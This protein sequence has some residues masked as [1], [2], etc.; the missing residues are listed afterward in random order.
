MAKLGKAFLGFLAQNAGALARVTHDTVGNQ[1]KNWTLKPLV[2]LV[3]PSG[4]SYDPNTGKML[5]KPR[6]SLAGL[7]WSKLGDAREIIGDYL[8]RAYNNADFFDRGAK[9][10]DAWGTSQFSN[11]RVGRILSGTAKGLAWGG[12]GTG[13]LDTGLEMTGNEDSAWHGIGKWNPY[14]WIQ[15]SEYSPTNLLFSYTTPIGLGL[16]AGVNGITGLTENVARAA[17][18]ATIDQTAKALAEM[19]TM[20]RLAYLFSPTAVSNRYRAQAMSTLD[21]YLKS[22]FRD[23]T[24]GDELKDKA[25]RDVAAVKNNSRY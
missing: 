11:P 17:S 3:K 13:L 5:Y 25:L 22:S 18:T 20:E 8:G 6:K 21:N 24:T 14:Q 7:K 16:T 9:Y 12:L 10:L 23:D 15:M 2:K 1:W 19:G 4:I